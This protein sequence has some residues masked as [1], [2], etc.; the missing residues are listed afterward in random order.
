MLQ[1]HWFDNLNIIFVYRK[2]NSYCYHRKR[3][4]FWLNLFDSFYRINPLDFTEV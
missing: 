2:L 3:F 1:N 4:T